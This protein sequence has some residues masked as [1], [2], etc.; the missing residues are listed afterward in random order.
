[1][2]YY[3]THYCNSVRMTSSIKRLLILFTKTH[4]FTGQM[5]FLLPN[6]QCQSTEAMKAVSLH[7]KAI[8][9]QYTLQTTAL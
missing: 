5:H 3:C 1:M 2:F 4:F 6:Q 9:I 8:I 7:H